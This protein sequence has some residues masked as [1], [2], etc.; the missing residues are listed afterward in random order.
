MFNKLKHLNI[1]DRYILR[2]FIE[3]FIIS[4]V[5]FTSIIFATD[6]FITIVKQITRYGIPLQIAAMLVMLKL[7]S[8]LILTIPMGVLLSTILTVNRMNNSLEITILKACGVGVSRIAK[9]ILICSTIAAIAGFLINE[10]IAPVASQQAKT[11]TIWAIMQK[12]VPNGKRNFVF[13]EMRKGKLHRF[14]HVAS[15]EKNELKNVTILD[16]SRNGAIQVNYSKTGDTRAEGWVLRNGVVYTIST[17]GKILNTA[18]YNTMNFDNTAEAATKLAEVKENE[19]NYFDLKKHI[20]KERKNIEETIAARVKARNED[21]DDDEEIDISEMRKDIKDDLL[22]FEILLNEKLALP[23]TSIVFAL[24]AIPLAITGPRARFNR[25][26]IFSIV[27]LF[28][29]YILRALASA[30][31]QGGLVPPVVAAWLPNVILFII[32]Y[33]LYYQKAYRI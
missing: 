9:P 30:V 17:N 22:E 7:P 21:K 5:I 15:V 25:G 2:Q 1:L 6:A 3:T 26:L 28:L 16:L 19:L 8:M 27:V 20:K 12:N 33:M 18:V 29:F 23:F 24:I 10:V 31:G 11:L 13:K 14:F 4:L 32:G